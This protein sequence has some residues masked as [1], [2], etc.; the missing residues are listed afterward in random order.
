[1]PEDAPKFTIREDYDPEGDL[2]A[3]VDPVTA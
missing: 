2:T 1:M 3:D